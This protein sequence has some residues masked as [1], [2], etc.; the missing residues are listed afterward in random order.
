MVE[1]AYDKADLGKFEEVEELVFK[2]HA[3]LWIVWREP[4][5]IACVV[6]QIRESKK[7]KACYLYAAGGK[8]GHLWFHMMSSIEKYARDEGCNKI[9]ATGRKGWTRVLPDFRVKLVIFE[10]DIT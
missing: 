5:I 8:L 6:T 10:K 7:S 4:E 9:R 1:K 3:L 2:G